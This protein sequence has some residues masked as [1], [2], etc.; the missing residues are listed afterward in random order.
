MKDA[1]RTCDLT[2]LELTE[3]AAL[4]SVLRKFTELYKQT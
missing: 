2:A 4:G 3:M 1:K